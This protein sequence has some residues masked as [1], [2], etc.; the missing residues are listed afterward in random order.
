MT[1][2][3]N[4]PT[5]KTPKFLADVELD[6]LDQDRRRERNWKRFGPYLAERQWGTVREDYSGDGTCWDYFPHDHARSR[7]Y[8]WGEDGLLGLC[9]RQGRLCFGLALWNGADPILKERLFGLTGPEGNHGEDVKEQYFYLDSTPTHSYMRAL[10]KY[11]QREFPYAWLVDEN[12]RRGKGDPE[13]ELADTGAFDDGRYFDVFAE[14]AKASPDD[15][16][17]AITVANRG[18]VA[19]SI[20]VLPTLWFRN[21]WSW[22]R[23][24]E[25]YAER[26]SLAAVGPR[27][28]S[29]AHPSLGQY[30]LAV[31]DDPTTV[32]APELIFTENETNVE[33]LFGAP[34]P[35]PYVKDAFHDYIVSGRAE[36]VNPDQRGT[37]AAAV[38]RL[39]VPA[40][41]QVRLRLRLTAQD[42]VVGGESPFARFDE[43]FA[44]RRA[45]CDA[46]YSAKTGPLSSDERNAVRQ[47]YAGLLWSKQFYH[48][49]VRAWL[50]GDPAHP[51]PPDGRHRGRNGD[52]G[53]LYNRDV[54]SMPD[55]WE[56]PWFAAWDLAFH[57]IPF[58]RIDPDF[59]KEQLLLM[60]REWYMHPN[61][62]LP[63]YEFAFGDVNPPVHAWA[64]WRVYK[65]AVDREG[66]R[67]RVFLARIFKKLLLNFTWWVNRKDAEGRNLFSGG[68]LG[69]DNIGV[70][71]RSRPLPTG[72]HLEQA[73]G[74]AWMA[75][76]CA[77]MLSISLEL[78]KTD[79]SYEDM[80]S[81]FFEHF[82]RITDAMNALG[83]T[84]LWDQQDG[85]Y[86]D[87]LHVDD[88]EVP[89]RVRSL[90]GLLPLIAVEVL[91]DEAIDRLPAFRRRMRWFLENRRDLAGRV[92]LGVGAQGHDGKDPGS[93]V[94]LAIPSKERLVKVLRYMLDE[95]EFLSPYGIRS[96]SKVHAREPYRFFH[97]NEEFRVD[98]VPGESNTGLFGGNSNWRGPIWMPV[99]Y[100]L[101]EA[102]ERYHHFYGDGLRVECPV[103]SGRFLNLSQVA[104]ELAGRLG[105]IFLADG[106]G[107]RPCHGGDARFAEDP[108]WRDLVLFHEYFHGETGRGVGASHQTGWTALAIRFIEEIARSRVTAAPANHADVRVAAQV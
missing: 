44:A 83:G 18:P 56:Y 54:L 39:T 107:R 10:Y 53:H 96:V 86:Y 22:G 42:E 78:A 41:G 37:K 62:Q 58:A 31:D 72:G 2:P 43:I 4:T 28:I 81:K 55:K 104:K 89:L 33:R 52:W 105:R 48:Y 95:T 79:P 98:Y 7:A 35:A 94:L 59:A 19:A 57:M 47:A 23:A 73:D 45:E 97:G 3:P 38:F 76:F 20:A 101:V 91:E 66:R 106:R 11:P 65:I 84:G 103:G 77:T 49:D 14:Y 46:F 16:L 29:I 64:A 5:K 80:A 108:H 71:D 90:V 100:L 51:A 24:G 99:N 50:E 30:R 36:R 27:E 67:D 15:V 34:N 69:L 17:I 1:T 26:P 60:T 13:F 102:L 9:D 70:F 82:V 21:I 75:F 68:F 93:H 12:R 92:S 74:T 6:R 8:R 32:R 40:G 87:S 61:G 88:R 85:F 63:A 25:G